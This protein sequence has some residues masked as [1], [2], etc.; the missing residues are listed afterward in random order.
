MEPRRGRSQARQRSSQAGPFRARFATAALHLDW[1]AAAVN[2]AV[3]ARC[4]CDACTDVGLGMGGLPDYVARLDAEDRRSEVLILL[5]GEG[6]GLR[7]SM[8]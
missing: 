7:V 6:I 5:S 2:D 1:F 4:G 3:V 8:R